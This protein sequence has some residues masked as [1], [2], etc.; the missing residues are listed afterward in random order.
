MT[1]AFFIAIDA[2]QWEEDVFQLLQSADGKVFSLWSF[3]FSNK[4]HVYPNIDACL[5]GRNCWSETKLYILYF[6]DAKKCI[7]KDMWIMTG[8]K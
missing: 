4:R 3:L 2:G 7:Y 5:D 8:V 6:L 1:A